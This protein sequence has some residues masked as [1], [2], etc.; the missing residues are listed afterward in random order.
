MKSGNDTA[1]ELK[2]KVFELLSMNREY[3]DD[4]IREII[5]SLIVT[6]CHTTI[7]SIA[8]RIS[9]RNQIFHSIREL[10][11]L[12]ELLQDETI[13]EIMVNGPNHIFVEQVGMVHEIEGGFE[14]EELLLQTIQ[15]IAGSCNRIIND[16][17]PIVDARL[18]DGSRVNMVLRSVALNG[19]IVTIR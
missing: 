7:F 12:Q 17:N 16:A 10:G 6:E 14:T 9:I 18:K 8:E 11:I 19:P 3:S 1:C 5:D 4:E 13:T 15:Q 2:K